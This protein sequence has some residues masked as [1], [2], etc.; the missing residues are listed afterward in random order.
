MF[1]WRKFFLICINE[2]E[3][4]PG[5]SPGPWAWCSW[6]TYTRL[7]LD[8][9]YWSAPMLKEED[10]GKHGTYDPGSW[11]QPFLYSDISHFILPRKF[12]WESD[13]STSYSYTKHTQNINVISESLTRGDIEHRLSEFA[14][15]VKLY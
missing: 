15:E 12:F 5:P 2:L 11:G 1:D 4:H 9:G 14:L 7:A 10:L 13:S 3:N 6:T 8:C